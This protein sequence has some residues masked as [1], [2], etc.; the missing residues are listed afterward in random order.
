MSGRFCF[1]SH[2]I[3]AF[4]PKIVFYSIK[5]CLS[6][7]AD[8][9]FAVQ[10][11]GLAAQCRLAGPA[12]CIVPTLSVLKYSLAVER[13]GCTCCTKK[14]KSCCSLMLGAPL[15]LLGKFGC[16]LLLMFNSEGFLSLLD[17]ENKEFE[18]R[19]VVTHGI[20]I[21]SAVSDL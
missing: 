18:A 15:G 20:R 9:N 19:S 2:V 8:L 12:G 7:L 5:D 21:S 13:T 10:F 3:V 11:K 14:C 6:L 16:N 17:K 4:R 1:S